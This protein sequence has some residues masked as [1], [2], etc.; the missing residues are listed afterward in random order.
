MVT[1][2]SAALGLAMLPAS[3]TDDLL[4]ALRVAC[5][6]LRACGGL[7]GRGGRPTCSEEP[8]SLDAAKAMGA[9]WVG[10]IGACKVPFRS[11]EQ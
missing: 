1:G 7:T 4:S 6:V 11:V 3:P 9:R 8:T 2:G 5:S 10:Y